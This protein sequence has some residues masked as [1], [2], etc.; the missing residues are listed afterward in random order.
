MPISGNPFALIGRGLLLLWLAYWSVAFI[1]SPIAANAAG[2]SFLHGVNLPFHEFGHILFRPFPPV[3]TSLGGSLGQ[4]LMPA[5]CF[6]V[7]LL[8]TRD[9]FGAA[10]CLWWFG[11]NFL[12]IAPYIDDARSLS[13]PLIG[14]NFGD[15]SPYGFHDWEF[16]LGQTGLLTY[17]HRFA[18]IA[19]GLGAVV[20]AGALVWAMVLLFRPAAAEPR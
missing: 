12:D 15:T 9:A 2:E 1:F 16:I 7:L 5:I 13:L 19:K 11:E 8:K 4:L 10:V 20:M 18:A 3:I 14:G 6:F 17:D